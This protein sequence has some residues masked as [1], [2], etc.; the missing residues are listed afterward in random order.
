MLRQ[1]ARPVA[2]RVG[3]INEQPANEVGFQFVLLEVQPFLPAEHLPVDVPDVVPGD[4]LAVLG[5]LDRKA[6]LFAAVPAGKD[7]LDRPPG[8]QFKGPDFRKDIGIEAGH[9]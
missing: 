8:A 5:E 1:F 3:T 2:H 6:V 4:I 7:P 9:A